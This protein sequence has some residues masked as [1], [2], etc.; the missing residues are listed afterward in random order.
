[1]NFTVTQKELNAALNIVIKAVKSNPVFPI[2]EYVK[3]VV[4]TDKIVLTCSNQGVELSASIQTKN[5]KELS[6]CLPAKKLSDLVKNLA[7]QPLTFGVADGKAKIKSSSGKYEIPTESVEDFPVFAIDKDADTF[8]L[9]ASDFF[10]GIDKTEFAVL[11]EGADSRP[12]MAG[13]FIELGEKISFTATDSARMNHYEYDASPAKGSFILPASSI[14]ALPVADGNI[15]CSLSKNSICL[16]FE[17]GIEF[18]SSLTE[19][20]FPDYKAIVPINEMEFSTG[21]TALIA[22]L[23]RVIGFANGI[24]KQVKL[25][26][27]DAVI[28]SGEDISYSENAE[29]TLNGKWENEAMQIGLNGSILLESLQS[30]DGD[31]AHFSLSAP[32]R[33]VILKDEDKSENYILLMPMVLS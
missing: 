27:G 7:D 14:P 28:L 10:N 11:K 17:N 3:M 1:M 20:K 13:V 24:T 8:S 16:S 19:G 12:N 22:A 4:S 30:L 5:P 25:S 33:A 18:K 32:N 15:S 2:L 26:F 29:E 9:S 21:R 23:K 31:I 6:F